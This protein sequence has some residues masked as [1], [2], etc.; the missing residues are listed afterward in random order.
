M[1]CLVDFFSTWTMTANRNESWPIFCLHPLQLARP[2]LAYSALNGSSSDMIIT[3]NNHWKVWRWWNWKWYTKKKNY[4]YSK[5][6]APFIWH[7]KMP[8]NKQH[9][10]ITVTT[11]LHDTELL[12]FTNYLQINWTVS[13][14]E[15]ECVYSG[16]FLRDDRMTMWTY[17]Q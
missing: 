3:K 1:C 8:G 10:G 17:E 6:S 13:N 7:Y 9:F 15:V 12:L 16:R 14:I 5:H 11:Q 4:A 2:V